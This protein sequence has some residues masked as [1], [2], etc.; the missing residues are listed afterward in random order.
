MNGHPAPC[1][2]YASLAWFG[3]VAA[4]PGFRERFTAELRALVPDCADLNVFMPQDP[5]VFTWEGMS[6]FGASYSYSR[7]AV[8]RQQYNESGGAA[9]VRQYL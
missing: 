6:G 7:L 5:A 9:G 4:C 3:G 1:L 8:T 2:C